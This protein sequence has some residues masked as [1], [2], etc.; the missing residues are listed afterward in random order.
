MPPNTVYVGRGSKWGNPY[1][2]TDYN[3]ESIDQ[4][5]NAARRDYRFDLECGLLPY[6]ETDIKREL[7]GKN[8]A[9]WCPLD[10]YC[11]ADDLLEIANKS[12]N[13]TDAG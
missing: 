12:L 13:Q 7:S 1:K 11:H 5:R 3:F 8:L 9:C 4:C 6:R 10:S 2:T